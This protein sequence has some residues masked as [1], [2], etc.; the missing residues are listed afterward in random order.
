[1]LDV[2][3]RGILKMDES[4]VQF[5]R[6]LLTGEECNQIIEGLSL[7]RESAKKGLKKDCP[8]VEDVNF[9]LMVKSDGA[10]QG[11][12]NEAQFGSHEYREGRVALSIYNYRIGD[13][14]DSKLKEYLTG[15]VLEKLRSL[16]SFY[17]EISGR[18]FRHGSGFQPNLYLEF[19]HYPPG[20]GF[21]DWHT[22]H[23]NYFHGQSRAFVIA[24]SQ[25][26]EDHSTGGLVLR[27]RGEDVD[28]T[29]QLHRGDGIAFPM[30]MMHRVTP[31]D[32]GDRPS[33]DSRAGRWI[34]NFFYY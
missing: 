11:L 15:D 16:L 31:V 34:L 26:G 28:T 2:S 13:I 21:F 18:T 7:W 12:P 8:G 17:F 10:K 24:L 4:G 25:I 19:S 20:E 22:H 27:D 33:E 3:W 5:F 23:K 32:C 6:E 14:A 1:M 9:H 30:T 29:H